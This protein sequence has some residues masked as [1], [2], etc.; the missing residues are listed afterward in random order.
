MEPPLEPACH[1]PGEGQVIRIGGDV[2]LVKALTAITD[3]VT[4]L[5]TVARPGEPAPLD[6]VHRSYDEVFYVVEG[7][8]RF[9]LGDRRV[10]AHAGSVVTVPRGSAHTFENCGSSP[11]RVLIIAAPGRAA[12]MLEDIGVMLAATRP[13]PP[14]A[15]ATLYQRHDTVLVPP[16]GDDEA[17]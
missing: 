12:Q 11:G 7:Q 3:G 8:F 14:D 13:L 4:V 1:G 16:L 6:H 2:L 5:E 10:R 15:L 9:R 17:T